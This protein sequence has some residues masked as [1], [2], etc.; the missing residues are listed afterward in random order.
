LPRRPSNVAVLD[1][2]PAVGPRLARPQA[3]GAARL[4]P[5]LAGACLA[6]PFLWFRYPP[7]GDLAM[8]EAP[9]PAPPIETLR[10]RVDRLAG[11]FYFG[12]A[13]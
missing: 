4:A 2:G 3:A 5:W 9:L 1:E 8:H 10:Q 13:P 11:N 12:N 6:V 7:M